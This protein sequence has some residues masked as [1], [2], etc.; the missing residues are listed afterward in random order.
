M[1][2]TLPNLAFL[3]LAIALLWFPA[4]QMTT[5]QPTGWSGNDELAFLLEVDGIS[6][7]DSDISNPIAVNLTEDLSITLDIQ[8]GAN[9]TIHSG[10]FT[11]EYMG[12]PFVNNPFPLEVPLPSGY[13][14]N[15]LNGTIPLSSLFSAGGLNLLSGTITGRFTFSYSLLSAPAVNETVSDHFVLQIGPKGAAAL[16]SV[17][18]LVTAGFAIMAVFSLLLALDEFQRGILAARKMRQGTSIFPPPVVLRRKLKKSGEKVSKDELVDMVKRAGVSEDI[19]KRAPKAMDIVKPKSKV[20]VGKLSKALKL[21][22]DDGGALA[23]AMTKIGVLQTKSV[24]VPLKKV[25]F[26]G[27][28]LAGIYLSIVQL[29][30]GAIPTWVDILLLATAGLVVS[31]FL[32]YLMS[33]LARIPAMGYD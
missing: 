32:G 24:K 10:L 20:P 33:F 30:S 23:A 26:S 17:N 11:M 13:S 31:V 18:G 14:A 22:R 21:K 9:L 16:M 25:A 2:K 29:M 7:A 27:L 4:F 8:T 12:I 19:A 1:R 5:A 15:L 3:M 6:A 28:T